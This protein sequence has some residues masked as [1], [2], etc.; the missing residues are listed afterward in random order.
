MALGLGQLFGGLM[1]GQM[2]GLLGNQQEEE[3]PTQMANTNQGVMSGLQGISNSMFKGMSQDEVY[4]MGLAF[5]TLRL[6]P[7]Q[8]LAASY[9]TRRKEKQTTDALTAQ[10]NQTLAFLGN[11]KSDEFPMGR[12]DLMQMV[13]ANLISPLDAIAEAREPKNT[14]AIQEQLNIM[15]DPTITADEYA[16]LYPAVTKTDL[17]TKLDL[18][19][20]AYDPETGELDMS[21]GKMQVLGIKDPLAYKQQ[22]ADLKQMFDDGD[23]TAE[24]FKDGKIKILGA[25]LADDLPPRAAYLRYMA[26]TV[27]GFAEG[28]PEFIEYMNANIDGKAMTTEINMNE[29][30]TAANMYLEKFI[31][32][33]I[34]ESSAIVKEVDIAVT[35]LDKLGDLMDIL[36]SDETQGD[37]APF[38]GIFQPMLSQA[39]RMVTSMGIDRKYASEIEAYKN[40]TG[41]AKTKA[42]DILYNKLVKT[43]ITKVMTGSDVFPMISSLGIGARGLDTPAE[44]DFLISVMTGL[45][46]M[47]IDTLKYMTKFR[48][49]MYIDGL[50]KYNAKV[51]SGYFK[52][53]NANEQLMPREVIDLEPLYRYTSTGELINRNE[54]NQVIQTFTQEEKDLILKGLNIN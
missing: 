13:S 19:D 16:L 1:L 17:Q 50:E 15:R 38:T 27:N 39:A 33:H 46:N 53:H 5:N 9:E 21:D 42:R 35:Q 40:S 32:Q 44:R 29:G 34:E 8:N 25:S 30:N 43:E 18:I 7:D 10:K 12:Q 20:E 2:S 54:L 48:I 41:E 37:V 28:S 14:S 24:D 45:P 11:M 36:E 23:M 49:Q 4:R 22:V 26:M 6:E 3:Q 47:T 52:M 51:N 31:P